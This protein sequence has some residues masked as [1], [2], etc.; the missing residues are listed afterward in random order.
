LHPLQEQLQEL[1]LRI[2]GAAV[3]LLWAP[4][5]G[6]DLPALPLALG[7]RAATHALATREACLAQ[8]EL[9]RATLELVAELLTVCGC[10]CGTMNYKNVLN[11]DC[12]ASAVGVFISP[13]WLQSCCRCLRDTVMLQ[14][15]LCEMPANR[16]LGLIS[17][18]H[19]SSGEWLVADSLH[20]CLRP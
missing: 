1:V 16:T 11:R 7:T 2:S 8:L 3:P 14:D 17:H 15:Q 18:E 6:R 20:F 4:G 13:R 9:A 5:A 12:W 10:Q 19:D